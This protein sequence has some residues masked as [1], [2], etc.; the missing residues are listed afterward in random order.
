MAGLS[1]RVAGEEILLLSGRAAYWPARETLICA[2]LHWGKA[3]T[4]QHWGLPVP[5]SVLDTD[6]SRL[7][8]LA[9]ESGAKRILV[10]GD[11]IH[12]RVGV[13][14]GVKERVAAFFAKI[15]IPMVLVR[16]NHDLS[17]RAVPAG[18]N[19]SV[20]EGTLDEGPFRF[21]H[22]EGPA[23]GRFQ[24]LG[25]LHP[26]W[27]GKS[28]NDRLRLP[29]YWLGAQALTLPAFSQFTAGQEVKPKK[30]DR[31]FV[32]AGDTVLEVPSDPRAQKSLLA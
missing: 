27:L 10:L 6:L 23:D 25:H 11:L 14:A 1:V 12:A 20:V 5:S 22:D 32:L 19:L 18:W 31:L 7:E 3:E 9:R 30:G 16:G 8:T 24:W 26:L 4:F 21:R 15:E 17:L 13:S 28:G 2:D 29:C